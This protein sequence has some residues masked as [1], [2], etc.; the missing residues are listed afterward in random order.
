LQTAAQPWNGDEQ[1]HAERELCK[2]RHR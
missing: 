2:R 1:H